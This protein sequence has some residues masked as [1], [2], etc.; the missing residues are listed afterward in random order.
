MRDSTTDRAVS[1]VL[2]YTF[3]FSIVI[4]SVAIVSIG[5][6]DSFQN[7]RTAE[8]IENAEQAFDVL[9]DNLADVYL[10]GAPSR[11]TELSLGDTSLYT[12]ENVSIEIARYRS[13]GGWD[14]TTYLTRPLVQRLDDDRY[15]IYEMGAVF[16]TYKDASVVVQEPPI[17][18]RSD[19]IHYML[20]A[21]QSGAVRSIGSTTLL[22]R[23]KATNRTVLVSDTDG[24]YD[25][26][27]IT[28]DSPRADLWADDLRDRG[29]DCSVPGETAECVRDDGPFSSL[30]V[31]VHQIKVSLIP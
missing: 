7:A 4:A 10:E 3:V 28:I 12:G 9:H 14:N 27:A 18:S 11:A 30:Y 23:G 19:R 29:F 5:G 31:A 8:Q 17:L 22:V 15:L 1:E 25:E 26:F 16:R 2:G 24:T 6:I 20:P 21:L 13:G